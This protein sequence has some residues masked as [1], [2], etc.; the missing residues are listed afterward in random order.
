[1]FDT[2]MT[3]FAVHPCV[4][5]V[6]AARRLVPVLARVHARPRLGVPFIPPLLPTRNRTRADLLEPRSG[7]RLPHRGRRPFM[8][9]TSPFAARAAPSWGSHCR[10]RRAAR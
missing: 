9:V 4:R 3:T 5:S 10:I 8:L 2:D 6:L 7:D 1:M